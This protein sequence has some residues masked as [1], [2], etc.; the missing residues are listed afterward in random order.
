[1]PANGAGPP[2]R[3]RSCISGPFRPPTESQPFRK[4]KRIGPLQVATLLLRICHK[5]PQTCGK[6]RCF[7]W[8]KVSVHVSFAAKQENGL[9]GGSFMS[10]KYWL[11]SAGVVALATPGLAHAQGDTAQPTDTTAT[12]AATT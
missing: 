10:R 6:P 11:L 1:M 2:L 5:A 7:R 8:R 3:R 12:A 9:R 4:G